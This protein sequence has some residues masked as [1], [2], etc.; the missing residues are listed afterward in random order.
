M[1]DERHEALQLM[2]SL[3]WPLHHQSEWGGT[4]LHWAAWN[5]QVALVE[6]LLDADAP[7]NARDTRY[8][9]SP[10]AWAAHGSCFSPRSK[11][12]EADRD[13]AVIVRRLLDSGA[14]REEAV[15][16]WGE[17]PET[18]GSDAVVTVLRE[19]GWVG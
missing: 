3:G 6:Q 5:G 2:L 14:T 9:S 13:Y 1:L 8:G 19:R 11:G 15:N 18:L 7:V 10:I 16:R 4:P 12:T 17:P